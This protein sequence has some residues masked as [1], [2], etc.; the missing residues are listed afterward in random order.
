MD[1][2]T[3]STGLISPYWMGLPIRYIHYGYSDLTLRYQIHKLFE[4]AIVQEYNTRGIASLLG[5]REE[6]IVS[7]GVINQQFYETIQSLLDDWYNQNKRFQM[8]ELTEKIKE[9]SYGTIDSSRPT[10]YIKRNYG[11]TTRRS[12]TSYRLFKID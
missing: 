10:R 9:L 2:V 7:P 8:S 12:N 3:V 11:Y 1:F 5:V 4:K 6:D